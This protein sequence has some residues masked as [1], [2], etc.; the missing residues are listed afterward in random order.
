MPTIS[1]PLLGNPKG[2]ILE[3]H[4][5]ET[6]EL[7][8]VAAHMLIRYGDIIPKKGT[9]EIYLIGGSCP[10]GYMDYD[11][12]SPDYTELTYRSARVNPPT[13]ELF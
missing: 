8:Q 2:R 1:F 12:K 5:G 4:A 9:A 13:S 7:T 3:S 10:Y 11:R 6:I